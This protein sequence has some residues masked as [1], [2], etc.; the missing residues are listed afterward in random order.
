MKRVDQDPIVYEST[1]KKQLFSHNKVTDHKN[2]SVEWNS[3]VL[4]VVTGCDRGW[5]DNQTSWD[6]FRVGICDNIR[7]SCSFGTCSLFGRPFSRMNG[8]SSMQFTRNTQNKHSF[9]FWEE[10]RARPVKPVRRHR[11]DYFAC[12]SPVAEYSVFSVFSMRF[13]FGNLKAV[14]NWASNVNFVCFGFAFPHS[15]IGLRKWSHFF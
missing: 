12:F 5:G 15:V 9:E 11:E 10:N 2:T 7:Y 3:G 14:F 13:V 4:L 6:Y 8:I 1:L